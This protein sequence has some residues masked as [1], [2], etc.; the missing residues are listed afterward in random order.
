MSDLKLSMSMV[1]KERLIIAIRAKFICVDTAQINLAPSLQ[2][3]T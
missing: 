3:G 2:H 1:L